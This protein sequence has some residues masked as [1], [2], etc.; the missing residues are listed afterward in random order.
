MAIL[1][2][3]GF[4]SII[5]GVIM[6]I[7]NLI[8]KK[9]KKV[10]GIVSI[11]GLV[12]FIVA[13]IFSPPSGKSATQVSQPSATSGTGGQPA[14]GNQSLVTK[15]PTVNPNSQSASSSNYPDPTKIRQFF[16]TS[17][18]NAVLFRFELLE[19]HGYLVPADG[20]VQVDVF[21][22]KYSLV[23]HKDFSVNSSQFI[24]YDTGYEIGKAFEWSSPLTEFKKGVANPNSP[25]YSGMGTLTFTTAAGKKLPEKDAAV[26]IP[27]FTS[28]D[29]DEL[30]K[31]AEEAYIKSAVTISQTLSK[32]NFEVTVTRVGRVGTLNNYI[33]VDIEVKN[34]GSDD[35]FR[36]SG[37]ALIDFNGKQ[38][39]TASFS[40]ILSANPKIIQGTTI[41]G[42]AMF[43]SVPNTLTSIKLVFKLGLDAQ[44]NP[45]LFEYPLQLK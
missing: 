26:P 4:L 36:P 9:P 3:L 13:V 14:G 24:D 39:P 12:V 37:I 41:S 40:G 42:S 1:G 30:A 6:L 33:R 8:R 31:A 11:S 27:T 32:G 28:A 45:Y 18:G 34:I 22:D 21:D 35:Y 19:E 7:V 38:Y 43:A 15:N 16:A 25:Y 5:V 29:W 2:I 44:F 10:W 23:Y 20:T 17:I